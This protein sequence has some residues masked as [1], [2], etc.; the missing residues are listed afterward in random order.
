MWRIGTKGQAAASW[1]DRHAAPAAKPKARRRR[2]SRQEILFYG[3]FELLT[4]VLGLLIV[5]ALYGA[6]H[7][8]PP[9]RLT[10][11][12]FLFGPFALI[13]VVLGVFLLI[14]WAAASTKREGG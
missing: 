9:E 10:E 14:A 4:L 7:G 3:G 11:V 13:A 1:A 12:L 2:A 5:W 6:Y 8:Q